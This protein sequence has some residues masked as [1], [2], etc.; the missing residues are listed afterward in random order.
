M[1]EACHEVKVFAAQRRKVSTSWRRARHEVKVL[2][3]QR[4]E[5][6]TSWKGLSRVFISES[7]Y[8]K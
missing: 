5:A 7:D 2:A 4:R 8:F 1:E 3:A 6:S